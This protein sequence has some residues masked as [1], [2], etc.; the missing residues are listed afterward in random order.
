MTSSQL[1]YPYQLIKSCR[2]IF[3]YNQITK[4]YSSGMS[5]IEEFYELFWENY[6]KKRQ[7]LAFFFDNL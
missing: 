3:F 1:I 4:L 7:D 2:V 6:L 5:C